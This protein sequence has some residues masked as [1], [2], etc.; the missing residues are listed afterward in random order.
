MQTTS[1]LELSAGICLSPAQVSCDLGGETAIL[2]LTTGTY[3]NLNATGSRVWALLAEPT[4]VAELRDRL[5]REL[6]VPRDGLED[7][8]LPLLEQLAEARLIEVQRAPPR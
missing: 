8:L 5:A 6:E 2:Q 4:T 7:V 1:G 3:Y